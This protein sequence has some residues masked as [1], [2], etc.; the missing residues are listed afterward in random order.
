MVKISSFESIESVK[1]KIL[2]LGVGDTD[3]EKIFWDYFQDSGEI[4]AEIFP[5]LRRL[6]LLDISN[7]TY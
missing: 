1:G 5:Y 2:V 6:I 7:E 3:T 4:T